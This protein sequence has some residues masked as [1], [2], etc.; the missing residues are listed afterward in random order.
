MGLKICFCKSYGFR[1][2]IRP[3]FQHDKAEKASEMDRTFSK[4][5][6]VLHLQIALPVEL[7]IVGV[8]QSRNL[9]K[10]PWELVALQA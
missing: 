9:L 8:P 6:Q 2:P 4:E 1:F 5:K 3:R 10:H 7:A